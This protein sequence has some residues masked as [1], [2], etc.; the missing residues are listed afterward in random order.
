MSK[1]EGPFQVVWDAS[2]LEAYMTC[3]RKYKWSVVDGYRVIAGEAVPS[4]AWGHIYHSASE[5][6]HYSLFYNNNPELALEL[7]IK[8]AAS[9]SKSLENSTD[10]KLTFQTLL[11]ALVWYADQWKDD[12]LKTAVLPDGTPALEVRFEV[13]IFGQKRFSGRI[14]RIAYLEN[15]DVLYLVDTKTT[16]EDL[17]S[18]YFGGFRYNNQIMAYLY[19]T[20]M[21]LGMPV[22]GFII[23]A[24][25]TLV[26][27]TAFRRATFDV[28]ND[29]LEEWFEAARWI[30]NQ[31]DQMATEYGDEDWLPN[32]QGCKQFGRCQFLEI[33][34]TQPSQR[35]LLL[36]EKFE[37]SN[38]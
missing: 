21:I 20:R 4:R 3:P 1:F 19:V 34:S 9:Q 7:A 27:S 31:A 26:G 11:R 28:A 23:D 33:S 17:S 12:P 15:P 14:D 22:A 2:S 38:R 30:I 35:E 29:H 10:T 13:P 16:K 18:R 36:R 25:Q 5:K 6:R 24:C 8:E 37:R 32:Y